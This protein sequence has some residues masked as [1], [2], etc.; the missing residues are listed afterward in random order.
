MLRKKYKI[1]RGYLFE[2]K[3]FRINEDDVCENCPFFDRCGNI[4]ITRSLTLNDICPPTEEWDEKLGMWRD[5]S[6]I[7]TPDSKKYKKIEET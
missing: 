4:D 2:R 7:Y 6:Y 3:Y 1:I 5:C